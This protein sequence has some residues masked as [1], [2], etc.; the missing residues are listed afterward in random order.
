MTRLYELDAYLTGELNEGEADALE[1]AMFGAPDDPDLLFLDR[2]ARHGAQLAEHGT[3][4]IGVPRAHIDT[5]V[6]AGHKVQM[7]DPGP[8]GKGHSL[9]LDDDA[10][11]VVTMLAIGRND[12]ER[13]DVE[14]N[15]IDYNATKTI[16]DV[17]VDRDGIV[18]GLCERPLAKLAFG[19]GRTVANVRRTDG[20]RDVIAT[21]DLTPP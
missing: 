8:P 17:T 16:K 5:L 3:F 21:W 9:I 20:A 12:I 11:F 19:A 7:F 2:I 13:V 4:D 15:L 1:E 14:I 10:E 18:Y 6:A